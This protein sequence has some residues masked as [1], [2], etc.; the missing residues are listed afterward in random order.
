MKW[1]GWRGEVVVI[2]L[3]PPGVVG[4]RGQGGGEKGV[5]W[6][7]RIGNY[8]PPLPGLA[9]F[10]LHHASLYI[11]VAI[12]RLSCVAAIARCTTPNGIVRTTV[13]GVFIARPKRSLYL[14]SKRCFWCVRRGGGPCDRSTVLLSL[15]VHA[16]AC[17]DASDS[18]EPRL[19]VSSG[20]ITPLIYMI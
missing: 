7:K 9:A 2:S 8:Y 18:P 16:V 5:G 3:S 4:I 14:C 15:Q 17:T 6:A 1:D 10:F 11:C 19:S 12:S 20:K 13:V